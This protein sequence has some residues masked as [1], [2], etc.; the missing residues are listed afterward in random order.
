[1]A[2]N[3]SSLHFGWMPPL[4]LFTDSRNKARRLLRKHA[5]SAWATAFA[6]FAVLF[7][8]WAATLAY[9]FAALSLHAGE[10]QPWRHLVGR[11]GAIGLALVAAQYFCRLAL[12]TAPSRSASRAASLVA[13]LPNVLAWT[14]LTA[15]S[16][17]VTVFAA[18]AH[19]LGLAAAFGLSLVGTAITVCAGQSLFGQGL[20]EES[21]PRTTWASTSSGGPS[22]AGR[23]TVCS[24]ATTDGRTSAHHGASR[25][26][27]QAD[28]PSPQRHAAKPRRTAARRD[29]IDRAW[30]ECLQAAHVSVNA[31]KALYSAGFRSMEELRRAE[32]GALLAVRG[33]G[34]ATLRKLRDQFH[35]QPPS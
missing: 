1:M 14:V 20:K 24:A 8:S 28:G 21:G 13:R 3:Q 31:A 2:L 23:S 11:A 18:L 10:P 16:V 6:A 35:S 29:S 22:N 9:D 12:V 34:P 30:L 27:G 15:V 4:S 25:S 19:G 7:Y 5:Q 33:V 32:D 26:A 17:S